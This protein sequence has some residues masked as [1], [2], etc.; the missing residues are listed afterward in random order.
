MS[1]GRANG[2]SCWWAGLRRKRTGKPEPRQS[3]ICTR[4]PCK[5]RVACWAGA[6]PRVAS[7]SIVVPGIWLSRILREQ[8]TRTFSS[9]SGRAPRV[10]C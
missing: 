3:R 8:K 7:G 10:G 6:C 4:K 5:K 9:Y 1:S 2:V